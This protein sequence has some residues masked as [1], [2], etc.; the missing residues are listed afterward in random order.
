MPLELTV[1]AAGDGYLHDAEEWLPGFVAAIDE[2][3]GTYGPQ[4]KWVLHLDGDDTTDDGSP[5]EVWAF[6]STTL[7]PKSKLYGWLKA[8]GYDLEVGGVV[9]LEPLIGSRV[10]VFFERYAGTSPEGQPVDKEKVVK[11]RTSKTAAPTKSTAPRPPGGRAAL[12]A[13]EP[14]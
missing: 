12:P 8:L 5:R 1:K 3:D 4:L 7:S 13:D 10:D 2:Q 9:D 6:S 11:L 14:F